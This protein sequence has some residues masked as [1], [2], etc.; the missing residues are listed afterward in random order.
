MLPIYILLLQI[1]THTLLVQV[2]RTHWKHWNSHG[3]IVHIGDIEQI[4]HIGTAKDTLELN[5]S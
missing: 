4:G 1:Y 2:T 5:R 3:H